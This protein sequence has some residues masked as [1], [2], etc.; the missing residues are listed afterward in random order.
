MSSK[1][2]TGCAVCYE[3]EEEIRS[4]KVW[5]LLGHEFHSKCIAPWLTMR[6]TTSCPLCRDRQLD[7]QIV[8]QAKFNSLDDATKKVQLYTT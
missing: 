4:Q 5:L 3:E 7:F 8:L 1:E 6:N 2:K